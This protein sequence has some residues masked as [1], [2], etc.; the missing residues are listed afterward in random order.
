MHLIKVERKKLTRLFIFQKSMLKLS[1]HLLVAN[2]ILISSVI[3][4][5]ILPLLWKCYK[6][7]IN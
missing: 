5:L 2:E 1:L 6:G 3:L 4:S 7:E